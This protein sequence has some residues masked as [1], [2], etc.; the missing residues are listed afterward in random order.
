MERLSAATRLSRLSLAVLILL[1]AAA[2]RLD[3]VTYGINDVC[4]TPSE[5]F[6]LWDSPQVSSVYA[7]DVQPVVNEVPIDPRV[8]TAAT[9]NDS[10][11]LLRV[12][13]ALAGLITVAL[14]VRLALDLGS[15][16]WILAGLV[17]AFAPPLVAADRWLGRFDF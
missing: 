8:R 3:H 9:S 16:W 7:W 1:L 5:E 6:W 13:G 14:T 2:M 17:A 4:L 12:I 15:N 11:A 10:W